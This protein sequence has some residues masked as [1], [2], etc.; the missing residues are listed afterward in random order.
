MRAKGLI[1][2]ILAVALIAGGCHKKPRRNAAADLDWA[3]WNGN[4][5][6]VQALIARDANV[7]GGG[8]TYC[9]STWAQ[10]SGR[11]SGPLWS[12]RR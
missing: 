8:P 6:E 3:A 4:L 11:G 1:C 2:G 5:A 7:N 9:G 10:G 12:P